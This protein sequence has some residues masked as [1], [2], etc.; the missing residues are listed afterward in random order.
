MPKQT[1]NTKKNIIILGAGF[2]GIRA[3]R[4]IANGITKLKLDDEYETILID[5]NDHHLFTPLL[6]E[7]AAAKTNPEK[8]YPLTAYPVRGLKGMKRVRF[9]QS[10]VQNINLTERTVYLAETHI[11]F[12]YLVIAIGSEVNFFG[13][14]GLQTHALTLKTWEN[15]IHIRNA[16]QEAYEKKKNELRIAI[17]GGG[18]T[19]TEIAAELK[20][21]YP[22]IEIVIIEG[23]PS[24]L[25]GFPKRVVEKLTRRLKNLHVKVKTG[26]FIKVVKQNKIELDNGLLIPFDALIWTGGIKGASLT[27][28]LPVKQEKSG[29]IGISDAVACLP[30][31]PDLAAYH[32]IYAVGDIAC[33]YDPV[34]KLPAP[35]VA[36][37]A[38]E[39][40][41]IA[42]K[43]ILEN[44]KKERK[45][46]A[47]TKTYSYTP[48]SYPYIIPAGGRWALAKI[49]PF[50]ITGFAGW[51]L[52]RLVWLRYLLEIMPPA[53][54][55]HIWTR[56]FLHF[57]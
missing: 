51:F 29:R 26:S 8:L 46:A 48:K 56:W 49:G 20:K 25:P 37:A 30:H 39:E 43:N 32:E 53:R 22:E 9:I 50:I 44:I 14:P 57:S 18:S 42:A 10:E 45:R 36:R 13:I 31:S 33:M 38:I 1:F 16:I 15:A 21:Q 6:P 19:G 40:A 55:L 4:V 41:S 28:N 17:G 23:M 34:T 47:I 52:Q 2:G 11:S 12:S 3:A 5:R 7:I 24:L 35:Q 54:A 27:N